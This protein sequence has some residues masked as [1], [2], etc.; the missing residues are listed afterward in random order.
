M[1][2][3]FAS[4]AFNINLFWYVNMK[5]R[6]NTVLSKD[7]SQKDCFF[8]LGVAW[9]LS[10][11]TPGSVQATRK[12]RFQEPEGQSKANGSRTL[13]RLVW[14]LVVA[15]LYSCSARTFNVSL[16]LSPEAAAGQGCSQSGRQA[17]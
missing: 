3:G 10:P 16:Q 9:H 5:R 8:G 6:G 12:T 7:N 15:P 4:K 13:N 14:F 2:L 17:G 11:C 1:W